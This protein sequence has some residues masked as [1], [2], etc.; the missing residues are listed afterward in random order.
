MSKIPAPNT[1][2][3]GHPVAILANVV[4]GIDGVTTMVVRDINGATHAV[5]IDAV[6]SLEELQAHF[7]EEAL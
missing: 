4:I 7:T 6:V 1:Q 5:E 3:V 2:P